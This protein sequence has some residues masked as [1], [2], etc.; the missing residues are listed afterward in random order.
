[1][2]LTKYPS[3]GVKERFIEASEGLGD[4]RGYTTRE[5]D[6]S[7]SRFPETEIQ[8]N[9][10]NKTYLVKMAGIVISLIGLATTIAGALLYY[11]KAVAASAKMR[12]RMPRGGTTATFAFILLIGIVLLMAGIFAAFGVEALSIL[13]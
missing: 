7:P 8:I 11:T 13:P 1:M 12:G 6:R 2:A 5:I 4:R 10:E 9:K 3:P